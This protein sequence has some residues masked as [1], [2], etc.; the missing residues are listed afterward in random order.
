MATSELLARCGAAVTAAEKFLGA[1]RATVAA[2]VTKGGKVDAAALDREQRAGHAFAWYATY[3]EAL[4]QMARWARHLTDENTFGEIEQLI[5]KAAFAEYL[6]QMAGGIAMSQNEIARPGDLGVSN[7]DFAVFWNAVH[8]LIDE[9]S[10]PE[11]RAGI[12]AYMAKHQ[13]AM[14]IGEP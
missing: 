14:F 10:Q 5:L 11:V 3:V 4:R 9:G 2:K 12:A 6:A 1:A 13:G 7:D 8:R